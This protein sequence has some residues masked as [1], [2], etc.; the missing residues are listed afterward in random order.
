MK[1]ISV[2]LD[3]LTEDEAR[4]YLAEGEIWISA[5]VNNVNLIESLFKRGIL[6]ALPGE[7]T[8]VEPDPDIEDLFSEIF[9]HYSEF[10]RDGP[11]SGDWHSISVRGGNLQEIRKTLA[12]FAGLVITEK[13]NEIILNKK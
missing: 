5:S 11:F 2:I 12:A 7:V 13:G 8:K 9:N 6:S 10:T 3:D 1:K 4:K